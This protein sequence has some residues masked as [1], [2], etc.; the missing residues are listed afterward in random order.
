MHFQILQSQVILRV[1][2]GQVRPELPVWVA[3]A[4][5]HCGR[6]RPHR[7]PPDSRDTGRVQAGL[8]Q[9]SG[10]YL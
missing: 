2:V 1:S 6:G 10:R 8:R 7:H 3:G 4:G 9:I 5:P